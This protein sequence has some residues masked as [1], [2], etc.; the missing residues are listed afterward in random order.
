LDGLITDARPDDTLVRAF[1]EAEV[2]LRIAELGKAGI[3]A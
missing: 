2:E 3:A 1:A